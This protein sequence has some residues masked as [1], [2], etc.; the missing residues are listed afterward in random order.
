M[1]DPTAVGTVMTLAL[2]VF[3]F[4]GGAYDGWLHYGI[5]SADGRRVDRSYID[6]T[7][8]IRLFSHDAMRRVVQT[9]QRDGVTART[10]A[11]QLNIRFSPNEVLPRGF[12]HH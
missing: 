8:D 7:G 6:P 2:V 10:A 12:F 11:R 5:V 4:I 9:M 1:V 3:F